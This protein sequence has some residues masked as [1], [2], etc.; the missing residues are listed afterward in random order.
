MKIVFLFL[1]VSFISWTSLVQAEVSYEEMRDEVI[2]IV[3]DDGW[4]NHTCKRV[5]QFGKGVVTMEECWLEVESANKECREIGIEYVP[6][7]KNE[8]DGEFLVKI[9]MACPIAKVL[10]IGFIVEN[11]KVYVQWNELE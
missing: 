6:Q 3:A 8:L 1:I 11:G 10:G 7:V 9:L 2:R 5:E 4:E